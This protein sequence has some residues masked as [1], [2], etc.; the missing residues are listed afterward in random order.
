VIKP[1]GSTEDRTVTVRVQPDT[2]GPYI[3]T[4]STSTMSLYND[5][6][7]IPHACSPCEIDVA[8]NVTDPSGVAG[9]TLSFKVP[10]ETTWTTI[11]MT[12]VGGD[13]YEKTLKVENWPQGI[14]PFYVQ[15]YDSQGNS[16]KSGQLT[17]TVLQ[18]K[19]T[20]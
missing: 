3:G 16:S 7:W 18:C 5:C 6:R 15:A 13:S 2:Q 11:P 10:E 17:R 12:N 14:L 20:D 1:D 4:I 19:Y 9:V 8:V